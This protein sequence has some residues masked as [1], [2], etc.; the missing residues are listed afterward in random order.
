MSNIF[1]MAERRQRMPSA[2]LEA[3][4]GEWEHLPIHIDSP[5]PPATRRQI[6]LLARQHQRTAYDAVYVE[7]AFRIPTQLACLDQHL[8]KLKSVFD[9]II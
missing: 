7:L 8:L 1:V 3:I 5:P 2:D 6:V 9:W 4:Y